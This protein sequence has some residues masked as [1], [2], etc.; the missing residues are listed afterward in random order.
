MHYS[1]TGYEPF[2]RLHQKINNTNSVVAVT[3][4]G[5][6]RKAHFP[7]IAFSTSGDSVEDNPRFWSP[8]TQK[9][10]PKVVS[11]RRPARLLMTLGLVAFKAVSSRGMR[12]IKKSSDPQGL[13][14]PKQGSPR[15]ALTSLSTGQCGMW[16]LQK[17]SRL[18][19]RRWHIGS[20]W[21][22][23]SRR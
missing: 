7:Q 14:L 16:R 21:S 6:F 4:H 1:I 19:N 11:I 23:T 8:L 9:V 10:V 20:T 5:N 12:N 3:I 2:L 13:R 18:M 15:F 17:W 22:N